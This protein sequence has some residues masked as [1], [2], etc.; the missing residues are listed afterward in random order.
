[1]I[2]T[3]KVTPE[4]KAKAEAEAE[5]LGWELKDIRMLTDHPADKYLMVAIS[6]IPEKAEHCV[7][8]F[9]AELNGFFEGYY[10]KDKASAEKKFIEKR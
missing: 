6:W 4:N 1:M 10:T 2:I 3:S 5:R 8:L 9:N 7:H